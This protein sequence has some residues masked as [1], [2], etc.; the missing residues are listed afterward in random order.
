MADVSDITSAIAVTLGA[1]SW[2][3]EASDTTFQPAVTVA[4]CCA[5]VVPFG[6]ESVT[7]PIDLA[8]D[9]HRMV[10]RL[11]VEF[12]VKHTSGDQ[13]TTMQ[14]ARDAGT[15]AMAALL[16][17]DGN[18]YSLARDVGFEERIEPAF[19]QHGNA[20]WLVVLLIVPIEN[21]VAI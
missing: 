13:A 14:I 21:E 4:S 20:N 10:T 7:E 17:G 15:L 2:V 11:P 16:A 12:W 1:L 19:V 5:L 6:Q 9:A 8:G 18:G 3:D